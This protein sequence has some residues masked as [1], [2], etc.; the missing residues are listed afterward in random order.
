[1][2][3]ICLVCSKGFSNQSNLNKHTKKVHNLKPKTVCYDQLKFMY[4]CLEK[5]CNCSFRYN[6]GLKNH[7]SEVHNKRIES[8]EMEFSNKEGKLGKHNIGLKF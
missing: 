5:N 2:G 6:V 4:K 7:L 1:M 8:E 3:V